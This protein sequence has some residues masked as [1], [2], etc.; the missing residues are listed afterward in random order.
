VT[1]VG[2][3]PQ[4]SDDASHLLFSGVMPTGVRAR[5]GNTGQVLEHA[6]Q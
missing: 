2:S 1:D 4:S 3:G 5:V 6:H